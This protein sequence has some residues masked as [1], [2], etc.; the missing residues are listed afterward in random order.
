MPTTRSK[1]GSVLRTLNIFGAL[2][3]LSWIASWIAPASADEPFQ[4]SL[5]DPADQFAASKSASMSRYVGLASVIDGDTI[6]IDGQRIE[7]HGIDAPEMAQTCRV[8][9][10]SW[11]CGEDS[12][13]MLSALVAK[14]EVA[15]VETGRSAEGRPYAV[16]R[17]EAAQLNETMVRIGMALAYRDQSDDYA[18]DQEAAEQQDVGVWRSRF[19]PPWEWRAANAAAD[20]KPATNA[21][22]QPRH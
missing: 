9:I 14:R 16:C 15:C 21:P 17:T 19:D 2:L 22:V 11:P 10:F 18:L 12:S 6:E 8:V 1:A 3:A 7:L 13:R 5:S 20:G 4:V